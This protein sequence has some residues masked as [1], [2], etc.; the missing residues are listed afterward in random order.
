MILKWD[1]MNMDYMARELLNSCADAGDVY[2]HTYWEPKKDTGQ[3]KVATEKEMGDYCT[4]LVDGV[5]VMF[6]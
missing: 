6:K 2:T 3:P 5:N 1:R 4:E